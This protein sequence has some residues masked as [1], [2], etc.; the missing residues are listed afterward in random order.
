[1]FQGELSDASVVVLKR[2]ERPRGGE[3]EFRVEV[4][5][6]VFQTRRFYLFFIKKTNM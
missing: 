3:K 4:S 1:M 2:L 5:T 6:T